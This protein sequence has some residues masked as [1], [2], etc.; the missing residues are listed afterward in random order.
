MS[1]ALLHRAPSHQ[2]PPPPA[3][4]SRSRGGCDNDGMSLLDDVCRVS[5]MGSAGRRATLFG[6]EGEEEERAADG[7]RS[8]KLRSYD[9]TAAPSDIA[10]TLHAAVHSPLDLEGQS[11]RT[12]RKLVYSASAVLASPFDAPAQVSKGVAL[13]V[14]NA[15]CPSVGGCNNDEDDNTSSP[16]LHRDGLVHEGSNKHNVMR[17]H[18]CRM[19]PLVPLTSTED[20]GGP[21]ECTVQAVDNGKAQ[22]NAEGSSRGSMIADPLHAQKPGNPSTDVAPPSPLPMPPTPH[23]DLN[24]AD[25]AMESAMV[26][27]AARLRSRDASGRYINGGGATDERSSGAVV[28]KGSSPV[29]PHSLSSSSSSFPFYEEPEHKSCASVLSETPDEPHL[30]H[31]PGVADDAL[32]DHSKEAEHGGEDSADLVNST[33]D[34]DVASAADDAMFPRR[35]QRKNSSVTEEAVEGSSNTPAYTFFTSQLPP[36]VDRRARISELAKALREGEARLTLIPSLQPPSNAVEGG[37]E[38]VMGDSPGRTTPSPPPPPPRRGAPLASPPAF[39][40]SPFSLV[41]AEILHPPPAITVQHATSL[42]S[43][44][45]KVL[46]KVLQ[47]EA[48]GDAAVTADIHTCHNSA[49]TAMTGLVASVE[50]QATS[51]LQAGQTTPWGVR[52][53][54]A[55][56]ISELGFS[57]VLLTESASH[58]RRPPPRVLCPPT[59]SPSKSRSDED[60]EMLMQQTHNDGAAGG[61]EQQDGLTA[62][63]REECPSSENNEAGKDDAMPVVVPR[64]ACNAT[65]LAGLA[66]PFSEDNNCA[67]YPVALQPERFSSSVPAKAGTEVLEDGGDSTVSVLIVSS[68]E[69]E[70]LHSYPLACRQLDASACAADDDVSAPLSPTWGEG[71]PFPSQ[72]RLLVGEEEILS[73]A[74]VRTTMFHR[75]DDEVQQSNA[76]A[77]VHHAAA[78]LNVPAAV[79]ADATGGTVLAQDTPVVRHSLSGLACKEDE[80]SVESRQPSRA[81]RASP[82]PHSVSQRTLSYLKVRRSSADAAAFLRETWSSVD[83]LEEMQDKEDSINRKLPLP[84]LSA[85]EGSHHR[86]RSNSVASS[87]SSPMPV[88]PASDR[89]VSKEGVEEDEDSEAHLMYST[90]GAARGAAIAA[91]CSTSQSKTLSGSLFD[92]DGEG[93]DDGDQ[94]PIGAVLQRVEGNN[95]V[96]RLELAAVADRAATAEDALRTRNE[97]CTEL[98]ALVDRLQAEVTAMREAATSSAVACLSDTVGLAPKL[99]RVDAEVQATE[100]FMEEQSCS[101]LVSTSQD[102]PCDAGGRGDDARISSDEWRRRHDTVA[103]ELAE[104][105]SSMAEQLSVLDR[106]GLCPPFT[107]EVISAVQR[108]LRHVKVVNPSMKT[109]EA[110]TRSKNLTDINFSSAGVAPP[111][112]MR[113][114]KNRSV[115]SLLKQRRHRRDGSAQKLLMPLAGT[116]KSR[117][118]S[119][120]SSASAKENLPSL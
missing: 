59:P 37:G 18:P 3:S 8:L 92:D 1:R 36:P 47:T 38:G 27:M 43:S 93:E 118:G 74:L 83:E 6:E 78:A 28:S 108:R 113:L 81:A 46:P 53:A 61:C 65:I 104:V 15:W 119:A 68:D 112:N 21:P 24:R 98:H 60:E 9:R 105:K 31:A 42:L 82:R 90:S 91:G 72:R 26:E 14:N 51:Y 110:M 58:H 63:E 97:E 107:E 17:V 7:L 40:D 41:E 23:S 85:S 52:T 111:M 5:P 48:A 86:Q 12:S 71:P 20:A 30:M 54:T 10:T 115:L 77:N 114:E 39:R 35:T 95:A 94:T 32:I 2:P 84:I 34:V 16:Q 19:A 88:P 64:A 44:P 102:Q 49:I 103:K 80:D 109:A 106:L 29:V 25:A 117:S 76:L 67:S 75:T 73:R 96:L 79:A 33:R 99:V 56:D 70:G 66:H 116:A 120:H 11:E 13:T 22:A 87:M 62:P 55:G 89:G 4:K 101:S 69:K 100:K 57:S 45:Q 50:E